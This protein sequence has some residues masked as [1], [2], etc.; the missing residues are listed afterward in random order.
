MR[1]ISSSCNN[2]LLLVLL[3]LLLLL[4]LVF[5]HIARG[6][7]LLLCARRAAIIIM[8]IIPIIR[9]W[10]R[11]GVMLLMRCASMVLLMLWMAYSISN[12]G[13]L[14]VIIGIVVVAHLFDSLL[15]RLGEVRIIAIIIRSVPL[16]PSFPSAFLPLFHHLFGTIPLKL[17]FLIVLL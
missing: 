2:S 6:V 3:T 12:S 1:S 15:S 14:F 7:V 8:I 13:S 5:I 9:E 11:F 16:R 4:L 10:P 17:L